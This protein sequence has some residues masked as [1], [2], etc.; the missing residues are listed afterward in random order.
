ML[1]ITNHRVLHIPHGV[2]MGAAI[3]GVVV[4]LSWERPQATVTEAAQVTQSAA[5]AT[6]EPGDRALDVASPRREGGDPRGREMLPGFG[7]LV[8]PFS[9][10]R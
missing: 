2:A 10:E 3:I 4:A 5:I 7:P 9:Q 6:D 8:L 1:P